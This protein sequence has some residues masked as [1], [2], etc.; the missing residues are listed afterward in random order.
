[1]KRT[2]GDLTPDALAAS[3]ESMNNVDT[4]LMAPV[5]FTKDQHAGSLGVAFLRAKDG[6]WVVVSDWIKAK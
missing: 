1:M 4:G 2:K 5:S 3:L 6:R